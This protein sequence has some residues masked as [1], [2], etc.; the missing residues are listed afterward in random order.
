MAGLTKKD[1]VY[2]KDLLLEKRKEVQ[3]V[4]EERKRNNLREDNE[5]MVEEIDQA[6]KASEQALNLRLLDKDLKLLTEIDNALVKIDDGNYG[7]CEGTGDWIE[8]KRLEIRPWTRYSIEHK[9]ELERRKK[10]SKF[11]T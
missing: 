6:T 5:V 4:I 9:Q 11:G 3:K 10:A 1:I 7:I 8:R 2:F